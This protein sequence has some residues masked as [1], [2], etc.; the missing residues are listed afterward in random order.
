MVFETAYGRRELQLIGRVYGSVEEV[1]NVYQHNEAT[2]HAGNTF[3]DFI[4]PCTADF[5]E[6]V[7]RN[8]IEGCITETLAGIVVCAASLMSPE[9]YDPSGLHQ[10]WWTKLTN[11]PVHSLL[12]VVAADFH[13]GQHRSVATRANS[14]QRMVDTVL[15]YYKLFYASPSG[16]GVSP[17]N[18][19][20]L[21]DGAVRAG[22]VL[23]QC[24]GESLGQD[25]LSA[26]ALMLL[27]RPVDRTW[28]TA[29][30]PNTRF[31]FIAFCFV[32]GGVKRPQTSEQP[33]RTTITL[34]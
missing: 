21:I 14:I 3:D 6:L 34:L 24:S 18:F 26:D 27:V 20:G 22:D 9:S 19:L 17:N 12:A 11:A 29:S 7:F 30:G 23:L 16:Y 32:A 2:D 1:C 31:R 15:R 10:H 13:T 25:H 4:R 28:R 5:K 33:R 8:G